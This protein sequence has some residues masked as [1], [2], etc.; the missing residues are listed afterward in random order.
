M[1]LSGCS[2]LVMSTELEFDDA[3]LDSNGCR[4]D[5]RRWLLRLVLA[6]GRPKYSSV[7]CSGDVQLEVPG[8]FGV[9]PSKARHGWPGPGTVRHGVAGRGR[10]QQGRA[11]AFP[12]AL[13]SSYGQTWRG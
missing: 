10:Q 5:R 1:H 13:M 3:V 6:I 8:S 4:G 2:Q 7:F 9:S 12:A 11:P